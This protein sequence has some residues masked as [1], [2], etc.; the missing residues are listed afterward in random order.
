MTTKRSLVIAAILCVFIS[1][2]STIWYFASQH[3]SIFLTKQKA[4]NTGNIEISGYPFN[5]N[6][7]ITQQDAQIESVTFNIFSKKLYITMEK[8]GF[9]KL[10][11]N[12]ATSFLNEIDTLKISTKLDSYFTLI[13]LIHDQ[14]TKLDAIDAFNLFSEI[15]LDIKAEIRDPY[16][17]MIVPFSGNVTLSLPGKRIYTDSEDILSDLPKNLTLN[18]EIEEKAITV[19][20]MPQFLQKIIGF[21]YPVKSNFKIIASLGDNAID[22]RKM[23]EQAYM[24]LIQSMNIEC[25][26][27]ADSKSNNTAMHILSKTESD[28]YTIN[29]LNST[30]YKEG[31]VKNFYTALAAE[32]ISELITSILHNL[33]MQLTDDSKLKFKLFSDI[34]KNKGNINAQFSQDPNYLN[35]FDN[36]KVDTTI[37]ASIPFKDGFGGMKY[38]LDISSNTNSEI[39]LEGSMSGS[40]I[41]FGTIG[42]LSFDNQMD[43]ISEVI[44][45][46]R[47][48]SFAMNKSVA[49][50][51]FKS[52]IANFD[53]DIKSISNS[54][55]S[56]SDNPSSTDGKMLYSFDI[57]K[58]D[59][60][61]SKFSKSGKTLI[62]VLADFVQL[63]ALP[64]PKQTDPV[65][66]SISVPTEK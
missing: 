3:I 34:I 38:L 59:M 41:P 50:D 19:S 60:M 18:G 33:G 6:F 2:Y 11:T 47:L 55:L 30:I 40:G 65:N 27:N 39:K 26:V 29:L 51:D 42:T 25:N 4:I 16:W 35:R 44:E 48:F 49:V 28:I 21:S 61:N 8:S 23:D 45:F 13:K 53:N 22:I 57:N 32:D 17:D 20:T 5:I 36:M 46:T 12:P 54:L 24:A 56:L 15:G 43:K 31:A 66:S 9:E 58:T 7:K 10:S 63:F 37:S 52:E 1:I 14:G 64:R 62:D